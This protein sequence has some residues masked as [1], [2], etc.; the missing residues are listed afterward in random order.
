[1]HN[2]GSLGKIYNII[3]NL[4]LSFT[5]GS[6]HIGASFSLC[7]LNNVKG[8]MHTVGPKVRLSVPRK[9]KFQPG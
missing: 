6:A 7:T 3:K 1:M 4:I 2:V 9:I 8:P 5:M